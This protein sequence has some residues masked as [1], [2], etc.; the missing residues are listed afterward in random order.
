[1]FTVEMKQVEM[2]CQI[3]RFF[4]SMQLVESDKDPQNQKGI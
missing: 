4:S 1:M 2:K 3:I